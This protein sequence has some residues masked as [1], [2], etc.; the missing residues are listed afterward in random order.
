M[1]NTFKMDLRQMECESGNLNILVYSEVQ[2]QVF[3]NM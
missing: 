1:G 3:V 2:L